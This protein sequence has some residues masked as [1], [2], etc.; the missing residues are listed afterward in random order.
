MII[1]EMMNHKQLL[2]KLKLQYSRYLLYTASTKLLFQVLIFQ[3]RHPRG[4]RNAIDVKLLHSTDP[5]LSYRE[6][7]FL[8]F[9][10]IAI[11]AEYINR[12]QIKMGNLTLI[13]I[14]HKMIMNY[15]SISMNYVP[16]LQSE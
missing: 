13:P 14:K 7:E 15:R 2:F 1:R 4:F 6:I 12:N 16:S 11:I 9:I 5:E 8:Y 3:S 10:E